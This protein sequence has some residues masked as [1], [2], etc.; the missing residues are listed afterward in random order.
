MASIACTNLSNLTCKVSITDSLRKRRSF[1]EDSIEDDVQN[2]SF[3]ISAKQHHI[4]KKKQNPASMIR[5]TT[6]HLQK[7]TKPSF[8]DSE[9]NITFA[10][11]NKTQLLWK[12]QNLFLHAGK[13]AACC[14]ICTNQALRLWFLRFQASMCAVSSLQIK[15]LGFD[16]WDFKLQCVLSHLYKSS[17]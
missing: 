9:N 14:L 1:K 15:H 12:T 8:Y 2:L 5:K 7:E 4:C 13:R 16:F 3:R 6:S 10:K 11:R 17:T